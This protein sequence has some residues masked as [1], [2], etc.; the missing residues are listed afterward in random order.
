MEQLP[1]IMHDFYPEGRIAASNIIKKELDDEN[2]K[3]FVDELEKEPAFFNNLAEEAIVKQNS[4]RGR[5]NS[6]N[7][8]QPTEQDPTDVFKKSISGQPNQINLNIMNLN[9]SMN[10]SMQ[11]SMIE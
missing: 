8:G 2:N 7:I 1:D 3:S 9:R 11:N 5:L 10:A 6:S 4:A